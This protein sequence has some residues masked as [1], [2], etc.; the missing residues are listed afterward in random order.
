MIGKLGVTVFEGSK[1][2][3]ET[4][5]NPLNLMG[6]TKW[7]GLAGTYKNQAGDYCVFKETNGIDGWVWGYR[8]V[9]VDWNTKSRRAPI[10]IEALITAWAPPTA[11]DNNTTAYI[12]AVC[13]DSG[14]SS[15]TIVDIKNR[16]MCIA[17]AKAMTQHEQGRCIYDDENIGWGWDLAHGVTKPKPIAQS[18]TAAAATVAASATVA[19]GVLDT[20]RATG[21]QLQAAGGINGWIGAA[22]AV[23]ALAG[24]SY[25]LYRMWKDRRGVV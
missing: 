22:L 23:L 1:F 6:K 13:I 21:E 5:N 12:K 15:N 16:G 19:G 17:L 4:C 9:F 25:A 7:Q 3:G 11:H 18:N 14:Y 2:L 24:L 20:V 10:T 8:A